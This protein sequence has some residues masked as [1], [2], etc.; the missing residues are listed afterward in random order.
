[1]KTLLISLALGGLI[2]LTILG[3]RPAKEIETADFRQEARLQQV[4]E[5]ARP[6]SAVRLAA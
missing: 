4:Q 3:T 5:S 1:M 6:P 2:L